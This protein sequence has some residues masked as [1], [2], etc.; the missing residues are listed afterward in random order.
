MKVIAEVGSNWK[1]F[2]DCS[3]SIIEAARAGADVVKFQYF[4]SFDLYG[5]VVPNFKGELPAEWLPELSSICKDAGIEFMCTAFSPSAYELV[6][7]YVSRH[8]IASAELSDRDILATVNSFK[9][10]VYLST[11]GSNLEEIKAALEQLKD[12]EVTVL[13]CV[14]DYPAKVIDLR[15]VERLQLALY[16]RCA[17]V[18]YSDHSIDVLN[19]PGI[20]KSEGAVVIEKHVNFTSHTDTPDAPHSINGEELRLMV[21]V[22][23]GDRITLDE[24]ASLCNQRMRNEWRRRP[25]AQDDG[26][27]KYYR[28]CPK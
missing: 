19:I 14:A 24:T 10:P 15:N 8:K 22:I 12:C 7:R 3:Q 9:K 13:Y 11:G 20:A 26:S 1:T 16:G 5:Q 4:K 23:K 17:G 21:R 18:G 28:P 6:D 27:I 2:E 25:V